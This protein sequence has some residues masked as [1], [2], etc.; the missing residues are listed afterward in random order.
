[1]VRTIVAAAALT[2]LF[3]AIAAADSDGDGR[4]VTRSRS[5]VAIQLWPSRPSRLIRRRRRGR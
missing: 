3:P 2:L 4:S 1:M 5:L